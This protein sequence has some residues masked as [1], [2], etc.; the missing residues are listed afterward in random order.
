MNPPRLKWT[1]SGDGGNCVNYRGYT[2]SILNLP[3]NSFNKSCHV[4]L[5]SQSF[6]SCAS[7]AP[8]CSLPV[9]A[10]RQ[11]LS[12]LSLSRIGPPGIKSCLRNMFQPNKN[13]VL[14][15]FFS[16]RRRLLLGQTNTWQIRIWGNFVKQKEHRRNH[17]IPLFSLTT[18]FIYNE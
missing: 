14:I 10:D 18:Q 5:D 16:H 4:L 7:A 15:F 6:S 1:M 8:R 2:T 13:S 12:A 9:S 17:V 3:E 11:S